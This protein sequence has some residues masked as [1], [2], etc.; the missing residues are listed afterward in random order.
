MVLWEHGV[1]FFGSF[2]NIRLWF[3]SI[4][5]DII[6]FNKS[7]LIAMKGENMKK[8]IMYFNWKDNSRESSEGGVMP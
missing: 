2:G 7:A 1:I 6:N 5:N 4:K 3:F 8:K